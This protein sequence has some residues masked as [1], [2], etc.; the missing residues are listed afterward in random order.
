MVF[1]QNLRIR[2]FLFRRYSLLDSSYEVT[3]P[4]SRTVPF[5][6]FEGIIK[7][8]RFCLM[9]R[10]LH[11]K[12]V[13][14][15]RFLF[16]PA[17]TACLMSLVSNSKGVDGKKG[18][19]FFMKLADLTPESEELAAFPDSVKEGIRFLKTAD[20]ENLPLGTTKIDG[21]RVFAN[22]MEYETHP[23]GE[24]I[25]ESH[26]RYY[27]IQYMIRGQEMQAC[28]PYNAELPVKVP[29]NEDKDYT[30][31]TPAAMP[32]WGDGGDFPT[33]ITVHS[34]ELTIFA[35]DEVHASG[36]CPEMPEKIFKVVVK[37]RAAE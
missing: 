8:V 10:F 18:S 29:Y 33:K 16:A 13:V 19:I 11:R 9:I 37:C 4:V 7:V 35:P 32:F 2:V 5:Y 31:H 17:V 1:H 30:L 20:L 34:K 15:E 36:I 21:D 6:G 27:D 26:K 12:G 25:L 22:A 23:A 3:V 28:I 24:E 14:M